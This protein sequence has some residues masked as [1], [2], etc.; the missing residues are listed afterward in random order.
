MKWIIIYIIKLYKLLIS[1]ILPQSCRFYPSCS[2]YAI[3]ALNEY[4]S[5][6][7]SY[8]AFRRLLKCHPLHPGGYDPVK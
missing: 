1:P 4:G 2:S 5:L 6:K 3:D 7:G 8:L